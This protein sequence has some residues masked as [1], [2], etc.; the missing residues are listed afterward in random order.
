METGTV[1]L[2]VPVRQRELE[3]ALKGLNRLLDD[4][5]DLPGEGVR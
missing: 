1:E 3:A 2:H 5:I 4:R